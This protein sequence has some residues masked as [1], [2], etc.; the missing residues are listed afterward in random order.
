[1]QADCREG[2]GL[3]SLPLWGR[4]PHWVTTG[5]TPTIGAIMIAVSWTNPWE[6][7]LHKEKL[8]A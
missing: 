2:G 5:V 8:L 6:W 3:I 7:D 1:M 4:G